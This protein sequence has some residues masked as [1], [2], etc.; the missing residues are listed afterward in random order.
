MDILKTSQD[1]AKAELLSNGLFALFGMVFVGAGLLFCFRAETDL[2]RGFVLPMLV[3]GVLL[4]ILGGGLLFGTWKTMAGF[5]PAVAEDMAGF[6]T[7]EVARAD[8]TMA[9]YDTAAFKVIPIMIAAAALM[10]IFVHGPGWRAAL[11]TAII[12]LG[13][14]MLIDSGANARLGAYKSAL[15]SAAAARSSG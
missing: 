7:A 13:I 6:I 3:A 14:I 10:I 9:Q 8:R 11:V 15:E 1:W 12:F 2:A 4:L 5:A